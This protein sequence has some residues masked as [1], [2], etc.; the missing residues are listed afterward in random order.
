MSD[1]YARRNQF[2]HTSSGLRQP[3]ASGRARVSNRTTFGIDEPSHR[4]GRP[5]ARPSA[6]MSY[7]TGTGAKPP[8]AR[9][10]LL[11]R[12]HC[13]AKRGGGVEELVPPRLPVASSGHCRR[14]GV[15]GRSPWERSDLPNQRKIPAGYELGGA[16]GSAAT[17]QISEKFPPVMSWAEPGSAATCQIC[18]EIP[19]GMTRRI[20]LF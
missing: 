10:D 13:H 8:M 7:R 19:P 5:A 11:G 12:V 9:R 6:A 1:P 14:G 4:P 3:R 17:C 20:P 18:V 16:P 15:K 2:L